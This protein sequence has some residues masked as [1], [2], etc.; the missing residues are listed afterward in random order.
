MKNY[1][2]KI[3]ATSLAVMPMCSYAQ[4]FKDYKDG[5]KVMMIHKGIADTTKV[6]LELLSDFMKE[7]GGTNSVVGISKTITQTDTV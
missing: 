6:G 5:D 1:I 2:A 4:E 7:R 3:L